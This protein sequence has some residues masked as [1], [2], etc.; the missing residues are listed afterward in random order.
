MHGKGAAQLS[1]AE[2]R[3]GHQRCGLGNLYNSGHC[4]LRRWKPVQ[5][6]D[7][8]LDRE[9]DQQ[10]RYPN[11]HY[12]SCGTLNHHPANQPDGYRWSDGYIFGH[13][14]RHRPAQL[15]VVEKRDSHQRRHL[16][17]LHNSGHSDLRQWKP[18][19]CNSQQL[20]GQRDQQHRH[21][22]SQCCCGGTID[23]YSA[24]EPDGYCR[25]DSYIF[26]QC[27]GQRTAQ[28]SMAEERDFH[29]QRDISN[30]YD[31]GHSDLRQWKPVHRNSQQLDR[32]RDQQHR[33]SYSQC[34]CMW[35]PQSPPSRPA[36]RSP[37]VRQ[38]HFRS[39]PRA[40]PRSAIS[41]GRTERPSAA[42]PQQP[43]TTPGHN[44][45]RQWKPVHRG[46]QQLDGQRDQQHRHS[47]SQCCCLG[48]LNHHPAGQPDGYRWSDGN[49]FG[50][51]ARAPRR[52][53]ISGRRTE[54]P[55]A[56]PLRRPTP[57]R[58]QQ[59][60]TVEARSPWQSATRPAA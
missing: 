25:S 52:S 2:E 14:L 43:Y 24:G 11:G 6:G 12:C 36:R 9:R 10:R 42:R 28:L 47:Y 15:P 22:Y 5:R 16:G 38:L 29:Q 4:D 37:L 33:H 41:G 1:V 49:I 20:D 35:H 58:P 57:P 55:S 19:H 48:T 30:L 3:N 34:C 17:D 56:A 46:S 23:H 59:P 8:Q 32:Q 40:P 26:G 39:P 31:S 45:L 44:N 13:R 51:R 18:V 60:R 50:R 27:L 54:Q 21:S 53:A 7:Q